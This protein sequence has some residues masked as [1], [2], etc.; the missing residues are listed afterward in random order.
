MPGTTETPGTPD[1]TPSGDSTTETEWGVRWNDGGGMVAYGESEN[2]RAETLK[3]AHIYG[4]GTPDP[5]VTIVSR[6]VTYGPWI[7]ETS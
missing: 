7:A 1:A 5:A 4:Y 2:A 6:T 3:V